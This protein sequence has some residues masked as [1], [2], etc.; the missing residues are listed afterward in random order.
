MRPRDKDHR[1]IWVGSILGGPRAAPVLG[2]P[3]LQLNH[4]AWDHL[5]EY[6]L[7]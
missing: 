7:P 6:G 2:R 5:A 4:V 3:V 1:T